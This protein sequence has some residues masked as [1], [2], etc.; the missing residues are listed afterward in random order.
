MKLSAKVNKSPYSGFRATRNSV[1]F[2]VALIMLYTLCF[3]FADIFTLI[4]FQQ[5]KKRGGGVSEFLFEV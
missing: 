1:I 3:N 2:Q 5:W 4:T